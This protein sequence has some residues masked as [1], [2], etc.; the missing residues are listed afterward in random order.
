M[1]NSKVFL[2]ILFAIVPTAAFGGIGSAVRR[3]TLTPAQQA[4]H[5]QQKAD[6]YG[7]SADPGMQEKARYHQNVADKAK[8]LADAQDR[9]KAAT[10]KESRS[11]DEAMD[12]GYNS[13]GPNKVSDAEVKKAKQDLNDAYSQRNR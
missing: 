9:Y 2:Y 7:K 8:N 12:L 3:A 5:H 10:V 1:K 13:H 4:S 11:H 6:S